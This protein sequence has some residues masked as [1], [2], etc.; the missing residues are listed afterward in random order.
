MLMNLN[1]YI[2]KFLFVIVNTVVIVQKRTHLKREF[3][4]EHIHAENVIVGLIRDD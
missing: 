4:V 1:K 3:F 2:Y